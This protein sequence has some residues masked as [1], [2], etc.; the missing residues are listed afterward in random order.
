MAPESWYAEILFH[1]HVFNL[2]S[3]DILRQSVLEEAFHIAIVVGDFNM[4]EDR[5]RAFRD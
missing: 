1:I 5:R 3:P 2:G 4:V